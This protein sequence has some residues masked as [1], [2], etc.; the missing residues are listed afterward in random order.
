M[1]IRVVAVGQKMPTWVDQGYTEYSRRLNQDCRLELCELAA[2]KRTK[3]SDLEKIREEEGD[4]ILG[5]IGKNH[6]VI[7]LEVKGKPW[8]TEQLADQ[9]RSWLQ[10][11][12]DVSL[13]IGGPEGM[14]QRCRDRADQLWSLS[15]LTLP[16][17]LVRVLIAEQLYRAW[18]ITKNHPYH[19]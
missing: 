10:G 5:A 6:R 16:H 2:S 4:K 13:L 14:S 12:Q 1:K 11:G 19:R 7:A 15:P 8:S 3:N 17:P 18:S 9:M